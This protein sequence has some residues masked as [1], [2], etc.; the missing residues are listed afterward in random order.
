M[1]APDRSDPVIGGLGGVLQGLEDFYKDIHAN[2]EL[3]L[4]EERTSR[5]AAGWPSW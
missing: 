5:K 1:P 4:Q 3:S 2:P